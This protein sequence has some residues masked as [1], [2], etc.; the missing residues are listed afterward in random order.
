MLK[1]LGRFV[2]FFVGHDRAQFDIEKLVRKVLEENSFK[3]LM[4]DMKG[5]ECR[6][7]GWIEGSGDLDYKPKADG[8]LESEGPSDLEFRRPD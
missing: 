1:F 4:I 8:E 5:T 7:C 2:C 3:I 6:R